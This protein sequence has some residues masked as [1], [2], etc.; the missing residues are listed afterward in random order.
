M[1]PKTKEI[2]GG[3]CLS[4][5][6]FDTLLLVF[7]SKET[8]RNRW[9]LPT[10][11]PTASN[12]QQIFMVKSYR[13][14]VSF[15]HTSFD[16]SMDPKLIFAIFVGVQKHSFEFQAD[17]IRSWFRAIGLT[18]Y[19]GWKVVFSAAIFYQS[20]IAG[21]VGISRTR[22]NSDFLEFDVFPSWNWCLRKYFISEFW[23]LAYLID[24]WW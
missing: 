9:L 2:L 7:S 18:W 8:E 3:F 15:S 10:S 21:F 12:Q 11:P 5:V 1:S 4:K 22:W 17:F 23:G 16:F 24:H 14:A 20:N 6:T 13:F 19:D